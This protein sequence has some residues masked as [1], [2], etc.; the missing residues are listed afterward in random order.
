METFPA[1][2]CLLQN[3]KS[4]V[5]FQGRNS[6]L[7]ISVD[8][9]SLSRGFMCTRWHQ[10]QSDWIQ[11]H[12]IQNTSFPLPCILISV[13]SVYQGVCITR[14]W[15]VGNAC[16]TWIIF[17]LLKPTHV[18]Y[19]NQITQFCIRC[20][21][22]TQ[23]LFHFKHLLTTSLFVLFAPEPGVGVGDLDGQLSGSLHNQLP[24]LGGDV[25]GDLSAVCPVEVKGKSFRVRLIPRL[26]SLILQLIYIIGMKLWFLWHLA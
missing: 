10:R 16:T 7:I 9:K 21:K 20:T 11:H 26:T 22:M 25:V 23:A 14:Q 12:N 19:V 2:S 1:G 4:E 3:M 18:Q 17:S 8:I 6:R 15:I 5:R 13:L 24:F